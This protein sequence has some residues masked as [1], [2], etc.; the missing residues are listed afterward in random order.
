[1]DAAAWPAWEEEEEE[2]DWPPDDS[3]PKPGLISSS[4]SLEVTHD[5]DDDV[6]LHAHEAVLHSRRRYAPCHHDCENL[7]Q[8]S[9][10]KNE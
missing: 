2:E 10:S 1:M 8:D 7:Q 3:K 9:S 5:G 6:C 4:F